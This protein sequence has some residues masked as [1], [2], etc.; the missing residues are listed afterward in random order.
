MQASRPRTLLAPLQIGLGVKMKL[1]FPLRLLLDTLHN[2]GFSCSYE[3]VDTFEKNAAIAQET[4]I[5]R[6]DNQIVNYFPT[7]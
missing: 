2:L 3:E 7:T 4:D 6:S 1:L 5:P